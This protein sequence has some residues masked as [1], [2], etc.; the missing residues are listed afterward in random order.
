MP[1]GTN[2]QRNSPGTLVILES[3]QKGADSGL[4]MTDMEFERHKVADLHWVDEPP[5][6]VDI[7]RQLFVSWGWEVPNVFEFGMRVQV[8]GSNLG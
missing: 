2:I 5:R 6:T 1:I 8:V 3:G 7:Q 4:T